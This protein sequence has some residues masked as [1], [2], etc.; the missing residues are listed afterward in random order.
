[1]GHHDDKRPDERVVDYI[2]G[3][4]GPADAARFEAEMQENPALAKD[5]RELQ[6]VANM[7]AS[8]AEPVPDPP[9]GAVAE[10]MA[11]ARTRCDQIRG[12][13]ASFWERVAAWLLTPQLAGAL[14][15]VLVVS[16]G[17]YTI[18]TGVFDRDAAD[19]PSV[20]QEMAPVGPVAEAEDAPAAAVAQPE[21]PKAK[22]APGRTEAATKAH[23]GEADY[24]ATS[25]KTA[26][27]PRRP[28]PEPTE[29][30]A[31]IPAP[32]QPPEVA[33]EE[34]TTEEK[35][36]N[37]DRWKDS[38]V[39]K[40]RTRTKERGLRSPTDLA[41]AEN[42]D[43]APVL[44]ATVDAPSDDL[45]LDTG[46]AA[47]A[48]DV[49]AEVSGE[50]GN[51]V[52]KSVRKPKEG[53]GGK[54]AGLKREKK[55]AAKTTTAKK[56]V[57]GKGSTKK[58]KKAAG[59]EPRKEDIARDRKAADNIRK[60]EA[61][62]EAPVAEEKKGV[63]KG[64]KKAEVR[65]APK[66]THSVLDGIV[67]PP[68]TGPERKME[69]APVV[70]SLD[71]AKKSSRAG[72]SAEGDDSF[73]G[74]QTGSGS[75]TNG[76]F[77]RSG[78]DEDGAASDKVEPTYMIRPDAAEAPG[79]A[80][81]NTELREEPEKKR[82]AAMPAPETASIQA[83]LVDEEAEDKA[84]LREQPTEESS[85]D[86]TAEVA[87]EKAPIAVQSEEAPID[88]QDAAAVCAALAKA[89]EEAEEAE[90]WALAEKLTLQMIAQGCVS[91]T[92]FEAAEKQGARFRQKAMEADMVAPSDDIPAGETAPTPAEAV[93]PT[94]MK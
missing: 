28:E 70:T 14:T 89:I 63:S 23:G 27:P 46:E 94:D 30:P 1:M 77:D 25:G 40:A 35:T 53:A 17:V 80:I 69:E 7:A 57:T 22:K 51:F 42:L 11:A 82:P 75:P 86:M 21:A 78:I 54:L 8:A 50:A 32:A 24:R 83:R 33:Q 36:V 91:G 67:V 38:G 61:K 4:L 74:A 66:V 79:I 81:E 88:A 12:A 9:E 45:A 84:T 87:K 15:L 41:S 34:P 58:D 92:D 65:S 64:Y 49:R 93:E 39:E 73:L 60:P 2:Y 47:V 37:K 56:K 43:A 13:E 16:V 3:E 29:A 18:Q 19:A 6:A 20:Q 10:A 55:R 31:A 5:V 71:L 76:V 44:D 59:P 26:L 52:E 72:G 90:D 68:P 48:G 85:F 62:A